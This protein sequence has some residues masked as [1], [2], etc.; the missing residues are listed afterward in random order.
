MANNTITYFFSFLVLMAIQILLLNNIMLFDTGTGFLYVLFILLLPFEIQGWLLL[1]LSFFTG[2]TID[3]FSNSLGLHTSACLVMSFA[4]PYWLK[5]IAP[6]D[7]YEFGTKPTIGHLGISWF[8]SYASV[9]VF[10]HHIWLFVLEIFKFSDL[11]TT[12]W[13]VF[14]S[15]LFTLT[16]IVIAQYLTYNS[17]RME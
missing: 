9:L 14:V 17:K 4:R 11:G 5:L 8:I 13:R 16:L 2:L 10:I 1:V 12:L 15:T 7:G 6:R 3:I